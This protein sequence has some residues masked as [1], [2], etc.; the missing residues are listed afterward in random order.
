VGPAISFLTSFWLLPQKLQRKVSSPLL[1]TA[2]SPH[3]DGM[4]ALFLVATLNGIANEGCDLPNRGVESIKGH[5]T[6]AAK[7]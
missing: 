6:R 5:Y 1:I 3:Q 7:S 2:W 4:W